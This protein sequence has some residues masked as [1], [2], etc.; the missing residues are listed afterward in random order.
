MPRFASFVASLLLPI[1]FPWTLCGQTSAL[2][3]ERDIRPVFREFCFDCHGA[4]EKLAGGLDLRL[5]RFL[6]KGGDSG[7][8]IVVGKAAASLLLE[9]IAAGE[10][11]PE[12]SHVPEKKIALIRRWIEQ[13]AAVVRAEPESLE[14]GIPITQEERAYWA[15]QRLKRS[16]LADRTVDGAGDGSKAGAANAGPPTN[17]TGAGEVRTP[18]DALLLAAMPDGL[19]FSVDADRETLVKRVYFDLLGLP[20]TSGEL[21]RWTDDPAADWYESMVDVV[22]DSPHYGERWARHWLDVA[23]YADS[24]GF[25]TADA[26]R[27]WAWKYRDYVIRSL[28]ADKPFDQFVAEQLAGDELAGPAHGDW[29][30]EQV[31][32]LTAVGFLR[33]AADGTGSGDN[34]PEARNRVVA[35]TVKIVGS[36]LLGLSLQCAQCHD[37]RYDP[38]SQA[39][40]FSIRAVFDPALDWQ[41]WKAP[42]SR[43]VSLYTA[44][45]RKL[46]AEVEQEAQ[47]VAQ[48]KSQKQQEY[49]Q[50]ALEKEL[51]KYD[52]PLRTQLRTAYK[53]PAKERSDEQKQLLKKH[54]SV[55]ITPGVLYQYLPKAAEELKK[56]DQKIAEIRKKKPTEEFVR[57]LREAPGHVPATHI[58][59]RG[60][61]QQPLREVEPGG[62]S[63]LAP[64]GERI[65]FP[66]NDATLPTTGRRLAFARWLANKQNP[67]MARVIANRVWMHHF[68]RGIV[69]TPGD[70][71]KLGAAPTHPELL[72]WLADELQSNGWSLKSL[73]RKI[74]L[75]TAWRQSSQGDPQRQAIDPEN[76]FYWRKPLQ[77]LD[78]EVLRDRMLA[79]SDSLSR[80]L[81]GPPQ[82]VVEDDTGQVLVEG[83]QTRRSIYVRVRRSQPVA[84]LQSFD[85]PVM[86]INCE[87]RPVSTVATQSLMLLNGKFAIEQAE[88]MADAA[89]KSV[90]SKN[91]ASNASDGSG[92]QTLEQLIIPKGA[93]SVWSYG[94]GR[95]DESSQRVVEFRPL[96]HWTGS[97]WQGGEQLPDSAIGWVLLHAA[98]GHP[99]N[100][101]FAAVRRWTA[102]QGG[103]IS[104]S[105]SLQHGSE[106][107]DGV[108]GSIVHASGV[109]GQW[110]TQHGN[111][112]TEVKGLSVNEGDAIDFVTDCLAHE[113]SD[114]F[115]WK[116]QIKYAAAEGASQAELVFDSAKQFRGPQPSRELLPLQMRAAWIMALCREPT[117]EEWREAV[118]FAGQQLHTLELSPEAVATGSSPER[119]VLANLCQALLNSNEF[120]YV[121]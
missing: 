42:S 55:N 97:Q 29:T 113:T 106:N 41:A 103:V 10:M 30:A 79:A 6:K 120:L 71:G 46:A 74:L 26:A 84:M 76:R 60:D 69:A 24:E 23:G 52:E 83:N 88:R 89:I 91:G 54:P 86:T 51:M 99:G 87:R 72:D 78:A 77:R 44:A 25:T 119:Q 39:D 96:G 67:V 21:A 5:V 114:S 19:T 11:P 45:D 9:R 117:R 85:A 57:S 95:L 43:L 118:E 75:S 47:A 66:S 49:M 92:G 90:A 33:M 16:P 94:S 38:I 3:F 102:P 35:D 115:S 80:E 53:A 104:I 17:G 14:P 105:G 100:P 108:R 7:P 28:N 58:F 31:E 50:Q 18:I 12:G 81:F 61:H 48:Q 36:S 34:S 73:H 15:F 2:Q 109:A 56:L 8:A 59:H 68:G 20:P 37:H 112:A 98:G 62:L 65:R 101:K 64:E 82:G 93:P 116:V 121:D 32:L 1:A 27:P 22:L 111:V 40:Y 107:G 4:T 70:F 63:V 110:K 13:G